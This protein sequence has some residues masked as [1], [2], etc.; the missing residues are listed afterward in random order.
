LPGGAFIVA[1]PALDQGTITGINLTSGKWCADLSNSAYLPWYSVCFYTTGPWPF[2]KIIINNVTRPSFIPAIEGQFPNELA[3]QYMNVTIV[4]DPP[5]YLFDNITIDVKVE[6]AWLNS[7]FVSPASIRLSRFEGSWGSLPTY[8]IGQ[9]D[10][11]V[12]FDA[13]FSPGF[14]YFVI[15]GTP[16]PLLPIPAFVVERL[17]IFLL[18]LLLLA[19]LL[20]YLLAWIRRMKL[21]IRRMERI[22][23]LQRIKRWKKRK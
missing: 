2:W 15:H 5:A 6:K 18:L 13:H 7:N 1:A 14:S 22:K 3:Y 9:D 16:R 12:L 11:Y 23:A 8:L 10:K 17:D 20:L 4:G 19:I 21:E